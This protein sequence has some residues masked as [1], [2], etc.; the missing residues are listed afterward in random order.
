[1]LRHDAGIE[2]FSDGGKYAGYEDFSFQGTASKSF[3]LPSISTVMCSIGA[4]L[5]PMLMRHGFEHRWISF[6]HL[7]DSLPAA[8][9]CALETAQRL[10]PR[11]Y[12]VALL[13][14]GGYSPERGRWETWSI[15]GSAPPRGGKIEAPVL[16]PS[17]RAYFHP[18]PDD[19]ALRRYGFEADADFN[20]LAENPIGFMRAMRATPQ[21]MGKIGGAAADASTGH[22]IGGFIERVILENEAALTNVVW[23]WPDRVGSMIDPNNEGGPVALPL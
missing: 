9:L 12:F 15:Y 6:Q 4:P 19:T 11:Y 5:I 8:M 20:A 23:R 13:S 3:I 16:R 1:M 2:L 18:R 14:I 21:Y 17:Q 7:L 22:T 10:E